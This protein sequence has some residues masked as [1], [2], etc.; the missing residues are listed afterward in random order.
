MKPNVSIQDKKLIVA[1]L[2]NELLE[3]LND[4]NLNHKGVFASLNEEIESASDLVLEDLTSLLSATKN[5][6][7]A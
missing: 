4:L 7:S 6:F 3:A 5:V 1:K 2:S